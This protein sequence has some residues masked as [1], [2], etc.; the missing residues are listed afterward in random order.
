MM[1]SYSKQKGGSFELEVL[2]DLREILLAYRSIGSGNA[3]DESGDIL[4][5]CFCIECK[6]HKK[7]T[8]KQI[9]TFWKKIVDEAIEQGKE[10]ILIYKENNKEPRV[11]FFDKFRGTRRIEMWYSTWLDYLKENAGEVN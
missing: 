1:S 10:P 2:R 9:L 4:T 11:M 7:L 5:K 6:F 3:K 8:D